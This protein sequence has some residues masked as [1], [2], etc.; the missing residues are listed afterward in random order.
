MAAPGRHTTQSIYPLTPP[1]TV[2]QS[3]TIG[4]RQRDSATPCP[5]LPHDDKTLSRDG[6]GDWRKWPVTL[7][8][9]RTSRQLL[10]TNTTSET[11]QTDKGKSKAPLFLPSSPEPE[12]EDVEMGDNNVE[13][14]DD[15]I[16]Y[17]GKA[18]EEVMKH[19][20]LSTDEHDHHLVPRSSG[21]ELPS[22]S[23]H[24]VQIVS[25][26]KRKRRDE[27]EE[28]DDEDEDIS[29]VGRVYK[30][31]RAEL[32]QNGANSPKEDTPLHIM[33][34]QSQQSKGCCTCGGRDVIGSATANSKGSGSHTLSNR[35]RSNI[36]ALLLNQEQSLYLQLRSDPLIKDWKDIAELV[37]AKREDYD[38]VRFASRWLQDNLPNLLAQGKI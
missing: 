31:P 14:D 25:Q 6:E 16:V 12:Q 11:I 21:A 10:E 17:M 29:F 27:E 15:E 2:H 20:I 9:T 35:I 37:G 28:S 3:R 32:D 13:S 1:P 18:T 34:P 5:G 36:L 24:N 23:G 7:Y 26:D 38:R 4:P 22:N 19:R 8:N 30:Y 33:S